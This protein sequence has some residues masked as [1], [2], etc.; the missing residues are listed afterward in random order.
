MSAPGAPGIHPAWTS[1]AKDGVSASLGGSRVWLTIGRGI[2]NE[3]YWPRVD[4][5]QIRDLGF[6]VADGNGYWSEVKR[7]SENELV[8]P[9]PGVPAYS[10]IHHTD[11]YTLRL[12]FCPDTERDVVLIRARLEGP[13]ELKLYPLLAPHLGN[14]GF[15]N[16]AWVGEAGGRMALMASVPDASLALAV[17]GAEKRD[18]FLRGGAGYVGVSD[19]WQ[20]FNANGAM[21]WTYR[22]A[23][24]GNVALMGEIAEHDV[25]LAL[26]FGDR[27]ALAGT[28]AVSSLQFPF[29]DL[30][31]RHCAYWSDWQGTCHLPDVTSEELLREARISATVLK[32]HEDEAVPG[33][34]VASLSV[35]W[36]QSR[37]DAGGYHLVW[38]RDLVEASGGLLAFGAVEDARRVLGYLLSTQQPDGHWTQNQWL[39]GR[40]FWSGIQLD[41]TGLP[42]ILAQ[43]LR[44]RHGLDG[45]EVQ[46]MVERAAT[47]LAINGPSTGQD[48]WEEDSGLSPFTLAIEVAALVCAAN[49]LEG[50]AKEYALELAD[51][52]NSRIEDWTFVR[53]TELS[54]RFNVSG[55]YVR[56][57]PVEVIATSNPMEGTV[58]I[59]NRTG[60]DAEQMAEHIVG[61]DFLALVRAGL[62]RADDPAICDAVK[63][64]DALLKTETPNGPVWHRYNLDGYGE[65]EDGS[66]YDGTGIGRGWPL[67]IGERGH[68]AL[69]AGEPVEPYLHAICRMSSKGGMIPEQ[70]W[71]SAD[72][73]ERHLW[74]GQP[75]GSAM[76]LVWAHAEYLKLLASMI[77]G[78]PVDRPA[79]VWD[80]YHGERPSVPWFCWRFTQQVRALPA[81]LQLRL[82]V[83]A[84][85]RV[86]WTCG[87]GEWRDVETRHTGLGI[88]LVDLPTTELA[89][90]ATI[91]F[92]FFWT[93][94]NAWE[95]RNFEVQVEPHPN[96]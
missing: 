29:T 59:K 33:A 72:I 58:I 7:D 11:H 35:P 54:H 15:G 21:T 13:P 74:C 55:Y 82:E 52:W 85:A 69:A 19:G 78:K 44:E 67:L 5:P 49:F 87:D 34:L 77:E 64:A 46:S 70:V 96:D 84:S 14:T 86:H 32:I 60:I 31:H 65:H 61:L 80:R 89:A 56:I 20:D 92:T 51:T 73:P 48:R 17:A 8:T 16:T 2:L 94:R 88:H 63:V 68:Y 24:N 45:L 76:P 22:S 50:A 1:S 28:L 81:G 30:W 57:A 91:T 27:P 83:T 36:G 25:V 95:G 38:S 75:S 4:S 26:G 3:V 71:D 9:Q 42:I 53:D 62:R 6:I 79:A 12:D 41:E 18:A 66:P 90:G 47:Y 37:D 23:E 10:A 39:D 93:E 40:P 43:D